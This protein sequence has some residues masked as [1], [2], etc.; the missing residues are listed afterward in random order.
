[1]ANMGGEDARK[2]IERKEKNIEGLNSEHFK[3]TVLKH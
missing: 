1:V 3:R 2:R